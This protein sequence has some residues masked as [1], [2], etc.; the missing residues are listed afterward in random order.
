MHL[1]SIEI[2]NFKGLRN[3]FFNPTTFGCLV[4][5]NNAGKS[6]VLQ[7]IVF[8]LNR[9]SQLPLSLYYDATVY[10]P[11]RQVLHFSL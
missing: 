9:P 6:S 1:Q 5:E 7:A 2:E 8:A 10:E 11:N 3:V 4:G